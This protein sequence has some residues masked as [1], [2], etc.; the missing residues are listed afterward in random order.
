MG[1]FDGLK[2]GWKEANE[3]IDKEE[4]IKVNWEKEHPGEKFSPIKAGI[5]NVKPKE[6]KLYQP[7]HKNMTGPA[8]KNALINLLGTPDLDEVFEGCAPHLT[9]AIYG[10]RDTLHNQNNNQDDMSSKYYELEGR[11]KELEKHYNELQEKYKDT[12]EILKNVTS[13]QSR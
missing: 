13:Q 8:K 1:F 11:Y 12:M 6:K 2:Q 3:R 9:E 7:G 4:E 5:V 10:I